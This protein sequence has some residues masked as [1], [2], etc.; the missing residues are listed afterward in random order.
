M[1]SIKVGPGHTK[2]CDCGAEDCPSSGGVFY[3]IAARR[4]ERFEIAGPLDSASQAFDALPRAW[5][6]FWKLDRRNAY[7]WDII[8]HF[9]EP[10]FPQGLLNDQLEL[11]TPGT[12]TVHVSGAR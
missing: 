5:L 1:K 7:K 2:A 6:F 4:G 11:P 8:K 12:G 9:G 3:V 10:P